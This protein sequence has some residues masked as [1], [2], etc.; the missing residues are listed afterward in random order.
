MRSA[1]GR[2]TCTANT[3]GSVVAGSGSAGVV[4]SG[5]GTDDEDAGAGLAAG[6]L[7][8]GVEQATQEQQ[9]PVPTAALITSR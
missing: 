3:S 4:G 9:H 5:D 8:V 2:R 1:G 6:V 7:S